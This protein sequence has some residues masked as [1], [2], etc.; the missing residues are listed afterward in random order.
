[1]R[2]ILAHSKNELMQWRD[3]RRLSVNFCANRF[4]SQTNGRIATRL[5]YDGLQVSVHPG[6]AQGQSQRSR[7][8][9]TFWILGMSYSVIDGLVDESR[10]MFEMSESTVGAPLNTP[11]V[12]IR[13]VMQWPFVRWP[14]VRVALCLVAFC[15]GAGEGYRQNPPA[16]KP[17]RETIPCSSYLRYTVNIVIETDRSIVH[18]VFYVHYVPQKLMVY[19]YYTV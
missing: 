18:D 1:M 10:A 16:A 3:V 12:M 5:A 17:P 11:S 7:D 2:T 14:F 4:F 9:L 15:P 19:K 8:T 13:L 6:C